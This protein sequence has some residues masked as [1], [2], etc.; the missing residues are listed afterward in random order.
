MQEVMSRQPRRVFLLLAATFVC[1]SIV[2]VWL[3]E[4]P[5]A[6]YRCEHQYLPSVGADLGF[7]PGRIPVRDW[8]EGPVGIIEIDPDG[9]MYAAG[10]R[11]GDIPLDH[12][13]GMMA[14]CGALQS[15]AL[16]QGAQIVMTTSAFWPGPEPRRRELTVPTSPS[17]KRRQL[18]GAE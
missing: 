15:A 4:G 5:F 14:F 10:F 11:A 13:G 17:P 2:V 18:P 1:L 3:L 9:P 8:P 7:R 6:E 12:H 16:G